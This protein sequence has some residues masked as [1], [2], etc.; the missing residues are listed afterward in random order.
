MF[1][2][3]LI[4]I[5]SLILI[6]WGV[7]VVGGLCLGWLSKS[8]WS[9]LEKIEVV[10]LDP[11]EVVGLD[12]GADIHIR[13]LKDDKIIQAASKSFGSSGGSGVNLMELS[14]D[15]VAIHVLELPGIRRVRVLRRL[16]GRLSIAVEERRP[17]ALVIQQRQ[18]MQQAGIR[19][20]DHLNLI[21]EDGVIFPI[22]EDGGGEIFNL[23]IIMDS[24]YIDVENLTVSLDFIR[25]LYY[26]Y[27]SVYNYAGEVFTKTE[28]GDIEFRLRF[29][30]AL[31]RAK[32]IHAPQTLLVLDSFLLQQGN[33]LPN[34]LKYIDLHG[35]NSGLSGV[36]VTGV[37]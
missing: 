3:L 17:I 18:G 27:K 36:V 14:L 7:S 10:D 5:V 35:I 24:V 12:G 23:P 26:S 1:R 11:Q 30:G 32:D 6:G 2:H 37:E 15:S 28:D 29:G 34:N 16:P 4:G 20:S 9:R 13:R 21:D 33:N 19:K 31:V 22:I 8:S 25:Q